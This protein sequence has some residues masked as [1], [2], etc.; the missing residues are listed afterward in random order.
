MRMEGEGPKMGLELVEVGGEEGQGGVLYVQDG[1]MQ[2]V[3]DH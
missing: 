1:V 2:V 3:T